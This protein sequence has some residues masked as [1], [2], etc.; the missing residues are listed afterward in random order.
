M[1]SVLKTFR[2]YDIY[3]K[4]KQENFKVII[5]YPAILYLIAV[6]KVAQNVKIKNY[7]RRD[8]SNVAIP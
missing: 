2:Y 8:S 5:I 1:G 6:N 3:R 7:A 4:N